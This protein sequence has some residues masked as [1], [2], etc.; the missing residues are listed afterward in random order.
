MGTTNEEGAPEGAPSS[1]DTLPSSPLDVESATPVGEVGAT[2]L[3]LDGSPS[4]S[5]VVDDPPV[6][7]LP[8]GSVS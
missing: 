3:C 7:G 8:T 5:I 6:V 2:P 4:P 1:L